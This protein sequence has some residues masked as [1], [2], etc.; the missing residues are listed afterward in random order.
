MRVP[1]T[2]LLRILVLT[3]SIAAAF[4]PFCT[5][6]ADLSAAAK[7]LVMKKTGSGQVYYQLDYDVVLL[8]GLTEL[9]AQLGWKSKVSREAIPLAVC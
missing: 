8:F 6:H 4:S 9:Q 2:S 5:I 1:S 7:D 3:W